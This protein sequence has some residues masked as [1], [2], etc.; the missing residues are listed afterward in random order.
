[1]IEIKTLSVEA[2]CLRSADLG[3]LKGGKTYKVYHD[4][5]GLIGKAKVVE[6]EVE[7]MDYEIYLAD[8]DTGSLYH[9][10]TMRCLTGALELK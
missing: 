6:V 2:L 3:K 7:D 10:E 5:M 9:P 4:T 8:V 1:M